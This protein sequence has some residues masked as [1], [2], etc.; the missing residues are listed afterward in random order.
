M[1]DWFFVIMYGDGMRM[2]IEEVP[3][4]LNKTLLCWQDRL[5]IKLCFD[6]TSA[7]LLR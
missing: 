4:T 2:S 7:M 5:N 3:S 1:T 6:L